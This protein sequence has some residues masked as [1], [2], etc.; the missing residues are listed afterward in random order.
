MYYPEDLTPGIENEDAGDDLEERYTEDHLDDQDA[1]DDLEGQDT[2]DES[3]SLSPGNNPRTVARTTSRQGIS[4]QDDGSAQSTSTGQ[5]RLLPDNILE[6]YHGEPY[7]REWMSKHNVSDDILEGWSSKYTFEQIVRRGAVKPGDKLRVTL[8]S[9]GETPHH[10][11]EHD[12]IVRPHLLS[13]TNPIITFVAPRSFPPY[14]E[15]G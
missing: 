1:E 10:H 5:R 14:K 3:S 6:S 15:G 9:L 12:G 8:T 13:H 7:D 11:R 2:E 4:D